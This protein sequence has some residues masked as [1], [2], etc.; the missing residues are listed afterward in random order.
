MKLIIT[1][2][3]WQQRNLFIKY[4]KQELKAM[5]PSNAYYPG[6]WNRYQE[7]LNQYKNAEAV[8][9][10]KEG[11]IP[12]TLIPNV[13]KNSYAFEH[14]AFCGVIAETSLNSDTVA[15]FIHKAVKFSNNEVWGTLSCTLIVDSKTQVLL[16]KELEDCITQLRYGSIG[17]NCWAGLSYALGATTWGAFPGHTLENIQSGIGFVHNGYLFDYPEKS[18]VRAPFR[19]W[20]TP[21]WFYTN[22]NTEKIGES[23]IRYEYSQSLK[24]FIKLSFAA[25]NG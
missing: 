8:G 23:L 2:K 20:P 12:W 24:D 21:A 9:E 3:G 16:Q 22:K 15:E 19:V 5:P 11:C 25:L 1:C 4:L 6:A 17:I 13:T 14:E 7:F 18:V 10:K